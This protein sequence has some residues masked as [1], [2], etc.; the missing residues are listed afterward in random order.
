M[1]TTLELPDELLRAVKIRA[2]NEG[3]RIKDVMA[4][5]I[6]RGLEQPAQPP[7]VVARSVKLPLVRCA[8]RARPAEEMTPERVAEI[9]QH[10][11][12]SALP[13]HA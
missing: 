5:L 9:L 3:R 12:A 10:E 1:K 6:S 11:D 13:D 4:E 8:H 7:A 2:V